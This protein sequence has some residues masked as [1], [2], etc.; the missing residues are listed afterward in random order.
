ML[1]T[2]FLALA[3]YKFQT[4]PLTSYSLLIFQTFICNK[5]KLTAFGETIIQFPIKILN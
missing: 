2:A 1:R 4:N 3:A 5:L